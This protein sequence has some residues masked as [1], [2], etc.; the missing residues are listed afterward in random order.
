MYFEA[1]MT[2]D[3]SQ[4][5]KI[6]TVK[7]EG[8]FKRI[9]NL[10]T[11]GALEKKLE[12]ETFTAVSILQQLNTAF[13]SMGIN[14][15]IRLSHD[16]IDFYLDTEGKENDLQEAL[17]KYDLQIDHSMSTCFDYLALVLEHEDDTFKYLLEIDINRTHEVAEYPIA[18]KISAFLKEFSQTDSDTE[19]L[20][21]KVQEAI[22]TQ[23]KY[24]AFKQDRHKR[25]ET[26]LQEVRIGIS[27]FIR[28]DDVKIDLKTKIVVPKKKIENVSDME[29]NRAP[30]YYGPH[31][32][33]FG[34]G[35]AL[36][37][38]MLWTSICHNNHIVIN[39]SHFETPAGEELGHLDNVDTSSDYFDPD[40]SSD[41]TGLDGDSAQINSP[42]D[43]PDTNMDIL[44][45]DLSETPDPGDSDSGSWFD[46]GNENDS[47]FDSWGDS[48]FGGGDFDGGDW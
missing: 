25:F 23:E 27:K 18:I 26:F 3:P 2:V 6:E 4:I 29:Y 41:A 19:K 24:T 32:G 20:R 1:L 46:F 33:Y 39:D 22:G 36:L 15:I 48:D 30:G 17:D 37:Y 47:L 8:S 21:N 40:I 9:L 12:R 7:P 10:M 31:Y 38:S 28:V 5:T 44:G 35:D 13:Q 11:M 16:D 34:F 43:D 42:F 45:N 14:N